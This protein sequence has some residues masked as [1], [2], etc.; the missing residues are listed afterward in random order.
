MYEQLT[1]EDGQYLLPSGELSCVDLHPPY[2]QR[3][4][5]QRSGIRCHLH[6]SLHVRALPLA[7]PSVHACHTLPSSWDLREPRRQMKFP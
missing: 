5:H 4:H 7:N 6:Q 2:H 3:G 1:S